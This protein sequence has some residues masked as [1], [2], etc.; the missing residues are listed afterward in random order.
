MPSS[1]GWTN[2]EVEKDRQ[3]IPLQ[4]CTD[5]ISGNRYRN[6]DWS[7]RE[8]I[9]PVYIVLKGERLLKDNSYQW[10]WIQSKSSETK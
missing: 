7:L 6:I 3:Q 1:D 10:Q 4:M 9:A 8:K 2:Y 5:E